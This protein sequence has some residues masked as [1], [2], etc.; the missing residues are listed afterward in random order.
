VIQETLGLLEHQLERAGEG[1]LALQ[2]LGRDPGSRGRLQQVFLNLFLNARDAM[3]D[4]VLLVR[5]AGSNGSV[6]LTWRI[7]EGH[8]PEASP[9][10]RSVFRPNR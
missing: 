10:L 7:A 5:S 1:E 4:G 9:D 3:E 2:E 6:W 8:P